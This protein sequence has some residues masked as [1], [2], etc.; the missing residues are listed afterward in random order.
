MDNQ[1][2]AA[3]AAAPKPLPFPLLAAV[4]G[5]MSMFG[6]ISIDM[7]LP[8][9]PALEAALQADPALIQMTLG[10]FL[11]GFGLAQLL[12]GPLSD[13]IGRRPVLIGGILLYIMGSILCATADTAASFVVAR[14]LQGLGAS[15]GP[16]M[17]RAMVRDLYSRDESA[18]MYS[19]LMLLMGAAPMIAPVA[20]GQLLVY[21]DWRAIF[22]TLT[23]FGTLC[24]IVA[25]VF[26]PETL[27]RAAAGDQSSQRCT[28]TATCCIPAGF[29]A[30]A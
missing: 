23:A 10:G 21:F 22:W 2:S 11:L 8:A 5:L 13:S 14:L 17:A 16:V 3:I 7:Y 24:L 4:L 28:I 26:A 19:I 1:S 29:S 30:I 6:A 18:K 12:F 15:A 27:P 20:G 9:L 25:S